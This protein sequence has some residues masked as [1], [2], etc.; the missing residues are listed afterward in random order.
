MNAI[1]NLVS[2]VLSA[3]ARSP[4]TVLTWIGYIVGML[5]GLV[6]LAFP[7]AFFS[8][9]SAIILKLTVRLITGFKLGYWRAFGLSF[10]AWYISYI[11]FGFSSWIAHLLGETLY[12]GQ[13][14]YSVYCATILVIFTISILYGI[15]IEHPDKGPVGLWKGVLLS[16]IN[17][18]IYIGFVAAVFGYM[19]IIGP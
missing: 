9:F 17:T 7:A 13:I 1:N 19:A 16:V 6:L 3:A 2:N 5:I 11:L 4:L 15:K 10:C 18:G 14:P 8:L 12:A